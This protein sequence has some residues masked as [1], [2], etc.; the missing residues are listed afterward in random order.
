MQRVRVSGSGRS[1]ASVL[2]DFFFFFDAKIASS[3]FWT[4]ARWVRGSKRRPWGWEWPMSSTADGDAPETGCG[5]H[6]LW[7]RNQGQGRQLSSAP[8]GSP[9]CL[10]T[11]PA[12]PENIILVPPSDSTS[13]QESL[14]GQGCERSRSSVCYEP[15]FPFLWRGSSRALKALG[16][17]CFWPHKRGWLAKE[18]TLH[19]IFTPDDTALI[20]KITPDLLDGTCWFFFILLL[21]NC[22]WRTSP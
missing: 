19:S 3:A 9:L 8:W 18:Q 1:S 6:P 20:P 7:P 12:H 2:P 17:R 13:A 10:S 11:G 22:L 16:Q 15:L 21:C 4:G 14:R 5:L